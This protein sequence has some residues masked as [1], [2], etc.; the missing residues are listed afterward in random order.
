MRWRKMRKTGSKKSEL[1]KV[2]HKC[3]KYLEKS[4]ENLIEKL[5]KHTQRIHR[6]TGN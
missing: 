1:C 6:W 3:R 5:R 2:T 4:G